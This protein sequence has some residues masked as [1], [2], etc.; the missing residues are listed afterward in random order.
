MK[1]LI[2]AFSCGAGMG[3]EP[4][5]GWNVSSGLA[6][7][8]EVTVVTTNEFK[9]RNEAARLQHPELN[10]RFIYYDLPYRL[11]SL[12]RSRLAARAYY[13]LW[14]M[15]LPAFL[16][17]HHRD[18]SPDVL[19]H[20]TFG[21]YSKPTFLH[22]FDDVPFV[23]GP[24]GGMAHPAGLQ[25]PEC[26]WRFRLLELLRM[27]Y[28]A[29]AKVD[30]LLKLTARQASC[31]MGVSEEVLG[32]FPSDKTRL[33][34]QVFAE[35]GIK[36]GTAREA[37]SALHVVMAGRLVGWKGTS[38]GLIAFSRYVDLA[39][40]PA[41]MTVVGDGPQAARLERLATRLEIGHLVDFCGSLDREAYFS[42]LSEAD[43]L[44]FLGT[45]E[46]GAFVIAESLALG[47]PVICFDY[48]EPATLV[49]HEVNGLKVDLDLATYENEIAAGLLRLEDRELRARYSSEAV[50]TAANLSAKN[51]VA[52]IEEIYES[53]R[54]GT[55]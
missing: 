27:S 35:E 53:V 5:V 12:N 46:P 21:S 26:G 41:R 31:I 54:A 34:S 52:A 25:L 19:H 29:I 8:H 9:Q 49:A 51:Q 40:G 43:V 14:Q 16:K 10:I 50:A 36:A 15:M 45:H 17:R 2:S 1:I 38:L 11:A 22:A 47:I 39:S 13:V 6:K 4:G 18:L 55:I 33:V 20:L 23:W 32:L 24:I 7:S 44:L 28:Q 30:P 48:G 37:S 3:S 42:R